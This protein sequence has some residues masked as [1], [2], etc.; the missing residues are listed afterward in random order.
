MTAEN[1]ILSFARLLLFGGEGHSATRRGVAAFLGRAKLLAAMLVFAIVVSL[2]IA[3][4]TSEDL[5]DPGCGDSLQSLIDGAVRGAVVDVPS[6]VYREEVTIDQPITLQAEPGAEIRG[7]DVWTRWKRNGAYWVK[8]PL[9][10]FDVHGRCS[11]GT[12]R[13]LWPE[14]V[15]LDGDALDQVASDPVSG[16]FAVDDDR[17]IVLADDPAGHTVEVTT[18][19][20]WIS[21]RSDNVTI[22]GFAMRHAANDSQDGAIENNGYSHWMIAGNTLSYAHGAIVSLSQGSDLTLQD[23]D[24]HHGGQLGVHASGGELVI[25]DNEIHDNNTE[26]FE[27]GWE[28]GGIKTSGVQRLVADRNEVHHNNGIGLWCDGG[29]RNVTYRDN[30]V[31]HN[32]KMGINFETGST[33]EIFDNVVWENGWSKPGWGWGAGILSSSSRNVEIFDNVVACNAD[34]ISVISADRDGTKYDEVV[35]VRVHH[36]TIRAEDNPEDEEHN[37]A[38]AW[39]QDW[40]GSLF[41]PSS[42][43]RGSHNRYWYS[44]PESSLVR[45]SWYQKGRSE[46]DNFNTT[47]GEEGGRYLSEAEKDRM[48]LSAGIPSSCEHRRTGGGS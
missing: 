8:G 46:L 14:Q 31:H 44:T 20:G 17:D 4:A 27:S 43:N 15:F 22:Q 30:R 36:N 42:G 21:G 2:A 45:F 18:R 3:A 9:P 47:P 28:A 32:R 16:Q 7:S 34:G 19:T 24:I 37:Y 35:N 29:C 33:A 12:D 10:T 1:K 26:G 39:L 11:E 40:E 23:N 41:E 48:V 25:R 5:A 38:L 6:C 13:C